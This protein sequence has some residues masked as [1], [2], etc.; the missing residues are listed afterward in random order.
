MLIPKSTVS[1]FIRCFPHD[2]ATG[3]MLILSEP[4]PSQPLSSPWDVSLTQ[5]GVILFPFFCQPEA[6]NLEELMQFWY[7]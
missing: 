4:H 3:R 5:R 7:N 6:Y 2:L 1:G